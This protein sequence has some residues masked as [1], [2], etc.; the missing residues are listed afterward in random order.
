MPLPFLA[1][2]ARSLA[3]GVGCRSPRAWRRHFRAESITFCFRPLLW[4]GI[5]KRNTEQRSA[6]SAPESSG[7]RSSGVASFWTHFLASVLVLTIASA[8]F[9]SRLFKPRAHYKTRN[10]KKKA[11]IFRYRPFLP[12]APLPQDFNEGVEWGADMPFCRSRGA[13]KKGAK[14]LH[15]HCSSIIHLCAPF[16]NPLLKFSATQL[17][18][19]ARPLEIPRHMRSARRDSVGVQNTH[20]AQFLFRLRLAPLPSEFLKMGHFV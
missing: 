2:F 11:Y 6:P 5:R 4:C 20:F 10:K 7:E 12:L 8:R 3:L 16:V 15:R 18:R 19:E 14:R 13:D 1:R 9:P 17:A